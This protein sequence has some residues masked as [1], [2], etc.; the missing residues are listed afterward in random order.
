MCRSMSTPRTETSSNISAYDR[1]RAAISLLA[2]A[3]SLIDADDRTG[4]LERLAA[5]GSWG[6]LAWLTDAASARGRLAPAAR[7]ATRIISATRWGSAELEQIRAAEA[8]GIRLLSRAEDDWPA[9]LDDL[10]NL[11]PVALWVR[12]VIPDL[13]EGA[14]SVVGSRNLSSVG[15]STIDRLVSGLPVPV[16]SGLAIG[17]D[18]TAHRAALRHRVRTVAVLPSGVDHPYPLGNKQLAE[19]IV[20]D[21]GAVISELPPG[22]TASRQRFLDRNRIIAAL[23]SGSLIIEAGA[24]SGTL[25]EARHAHR[26][27][28]PIAAIPGTVGADK[29]ISTGTA[30]P[31][32]GA[33]DLDALHHLN[34]A[35]S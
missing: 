18:E 19:R 20:T 17:A 8:A 14:V 35:A 21:G 29:L 28:R 27:G 24:I 34:V 23:G 5:E 2:R 31:M 1:D 30:F 3:A 26:L 16:I 25:S 32:L 4:L 12:G 9:G 13:S 6:A 11:A 10:G 33:A 15:H 22:A 7:Y